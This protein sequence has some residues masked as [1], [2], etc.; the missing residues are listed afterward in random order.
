MK[1]NWAKIGQIMEM[2]N[3][4]NVKVLE[5]TDICSNCK[6]HCEIWIEK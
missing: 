3:C 1:Y 6:E 5:H 4:C 2:S